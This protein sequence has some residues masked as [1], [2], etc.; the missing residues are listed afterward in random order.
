MVAATKA[1]PMSWP[2][3]AG[4]PGEADSAVTELG[5]FTWMA[6]TPVGHD[7]RRR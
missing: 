6:D 3:N 7:K 5:C 2:A 1:S 4:H